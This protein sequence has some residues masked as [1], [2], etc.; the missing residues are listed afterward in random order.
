VS[1]DNAL[2]AGVEGTPA[3]PP[4]P[5]PQQPEATPN[6]SDTM[7]PAA[8]VIAPEAQ[9][10]L[11]RVGSGGAHVDTSASIRAWLT[12]QGIDQSAAPAGTI[13]VGDIVAP[14]SRF[15]LPDRVATEIF[16]ERGAGIED[17]LIENPEITRYR[18]YLKSRSAAAEHTPTGADLGGSAP[19]FIT[20][21]NGEARGIEHPLLGDRSPSDEI[22]SAAGGAGARQAVSA[23]GSGIQAAT[24]VFD[25]LTAP[26]S[27]AQPVIGAV[28]DAITRPWQMLL[29]R[30]LIA[31]LPGQTDYS[32]VANDLVMRRLAARGITAPSYFDTASEAGDLAGEVWAKASE[33][34]TGIRRRSYARPRTPHGG[35]RCRSASRPAAGSSLP[36]CRRASRRSSSRRSPTVGCP[37]ADRAMNAVFFNSFTRGVARSV[38]GRVGGCDGS[39]QR[40]PA[41]PALAVRVR[42]RRLDEH[43]AD[44]G[45]PRDPVRA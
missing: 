6:A 10:G 18:D 27:L 29:G 35:H 32:G 36:A 20:G 42:G 26:V 8:T 40:D 34:G 4:A 5:P 23:I 1:F 7:V 28:T 22:A 15:G 12:A 43:R 3:A 19:K 37:Y 44:E 2:T 24:H 16:G 13:Q 14:P 31:G 45:H 21:P 38:G 33:S 30:M 39:A 17:Q 11:E 9:R 41:R 25:P